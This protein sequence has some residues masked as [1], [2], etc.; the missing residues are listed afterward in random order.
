MNINFN[1]TISRT[2]ENT[3]KNSKFVK[4]IKYFGGFLNCIAIITCSKGK[5]SDSAL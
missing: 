4:N 2:R 1:Q 5:L 3:K